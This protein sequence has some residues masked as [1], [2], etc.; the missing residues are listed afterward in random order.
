MQ[1]PSNKKTTAKKPQSKKQFSL[2][3]FDEF[4]KDKTKIPD[5]IQRELDEKGL[6]GRWVNLGTM[7][8][9]GGR[10]PK[11]WVPYKI[12]RSQDEINLFGSGPTE[13][14][15]RGDLVL[16]VKTQEKV[17]L[18]RAFLRHEADSHNVKKLMSRRG[19]ELKDQIR[20]QGLDDTIQ[21]VEGYDDD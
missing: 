14:F 21:V 20:D 7:K 16:A 15:Q 9:Y 19:K 5:D 12:Q 11:G 18:H 10:H 3:D 17:D 4:T 1:K 13:Y 8:K 2:K 6:V